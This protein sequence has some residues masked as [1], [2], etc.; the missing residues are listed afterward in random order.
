MGKKK[1][2]ASTVHVHHAYFNLYISLPSLHD[3]NV[4]IPNVI[5][6]P[7]TDKSRYFHVLRRT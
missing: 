1:R 5:D 7:D 4:K 6:L 3:Y 2:M